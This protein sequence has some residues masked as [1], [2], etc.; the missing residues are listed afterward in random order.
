MRL[1]IYHEHGSEENKETQPLPLPG[2]Q[3]DESDGRLSQ[4]LPSHQTTAPLR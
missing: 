1:A 4:L 3:G 2:Q